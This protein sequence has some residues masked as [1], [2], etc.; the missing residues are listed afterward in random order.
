MTRRKDPAAKFCRMKTSRQRWRIF[1]C[2]RESDNHREL[3]SL[4]ARPSSARREW[5]VRAVRVENLPWVFYKV[6]SCTEHCCPFCMRM[7]DSRC[8][9]DGQKVHRLNTLGSLI[10]GGWSIVGTVVFSLSL[11]L[12]SGK[13][14]VLSWERDAGGRYLSDLFEPE[15][16]HYTLHI[17][18]SVGR[19][20]LSIIAEQIN[21]YQVL[22]PKTC[23][24]NQV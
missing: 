9:W 16:N 8:E 13:G 3:L 7:K 22:S 18:K 6:L 23:I 10:G 19:I 15:V 1:H 17:P 5:K 11:S 21:L 20:C 2:W 4:V 24:D 14:V 12:I